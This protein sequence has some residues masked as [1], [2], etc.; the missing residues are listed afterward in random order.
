MK[1]KLRFLIPALIVASAICVPVAVRA[2]A[3][4]IFSGG[5]GTPL[6][7]SLQQPV[8]YTINN[9]QCALNNSG[10]IFLFDEAGNPFGSGVFL[11][12]SI[13]FSINGGAAQP[14]AN[15]NSGIIAGDVTANDLFIYGQLQSVSNGST[16]VLSA[17]TVTTTTNVAAAP[18]ANGSFTTFIV[19]ANTG[20]RCSTNGVIIGTTAASVSVSGR[21]LTGDGSSRGLANAL[22]YLIDSEG[23]TRTA[24]T[25]PFGYYRFDGIAVGQSVVI[26]VVSK[27]Y[28][29]APQVVSVNED[30]EEVNFIA[31]GQ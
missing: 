23:S 17:G 29:F 2:Q 27:G 15:G 7:I 8:A 26:T 24:R 3:N 12:G 20:N 10:P 30:M 22:V 5:S 9:S 14:I 11:A 16:V 19:D 31:G 1:L 18:P 4:L 21:V 13:T 25:S 6:S 28:Q